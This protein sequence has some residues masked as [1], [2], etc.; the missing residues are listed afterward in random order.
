MGKRVRPTQGVSPKLSHS[1]KGNNWFLSSPIFIGRLGAAMPVYSTKL[2]IGLVEF[3]LPALKT[4]IT[5]TSIY[6]FDLGCA[7]FRDLG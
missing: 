6:S 4:A 3:L 1:G 5:P 7:I 2:D